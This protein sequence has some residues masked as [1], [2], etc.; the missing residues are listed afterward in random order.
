MKPLSPTCRAAWNVFIENANPQRL[1]G[2]DLNRFASFVRVAHRTRRSTFIDFYS[3][4]REAWPL[5]D[6]GGVAL[7]EQLGELY[8]F[9]R[10]ICAT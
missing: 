4:V 2:H 1:H 3:L 8:E 7:A 10:Q 9:G 6:A 5:D